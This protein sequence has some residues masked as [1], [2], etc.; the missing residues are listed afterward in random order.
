MRW[1][2]TTRNEEGQH[3]ASGS[4]VDSCSCGKGMDTVGQ[5]LAEQVEKADVVPAPLA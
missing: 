2:A 1:Q 4:L 5:L 3:P